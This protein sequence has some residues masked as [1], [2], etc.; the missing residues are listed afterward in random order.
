MAHLLSS[1]PL[2]NDIG[3]LPQVLPIFASIELEYLL[4]FVSCQF[5]WA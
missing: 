3:S 1:E 5:N 4:I 2:L